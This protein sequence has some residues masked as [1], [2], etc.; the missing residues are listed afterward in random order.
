MQSSPLPCY[1][2]SLGPQYPTQHFIL[3][4]LSLHS[5]LNVSDQLSHPHKTT[6]KIVVLYNLIFTFFD[7]KLEDTR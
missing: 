3:G 5:S 2:I 1:L 6:G 4:N 7:S